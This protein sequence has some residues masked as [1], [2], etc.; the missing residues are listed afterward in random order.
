MSNDRIL[1]EE[2]IRA[3]YQREEFCHPERLSY[4]TGHMEGFLLKRGKEDSR[5]YSRK[6]ILD[7]VDGTLRYFVKE[8]RNPKAILKVPELN[9]VLSPEKIASPNSMQ[10]TFLRDGSTRHIYVKHENPE[11][12]INW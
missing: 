7:E 10:L 11:T 1:I 4:I 5:F 6:F 3:K 2:W 8:D 12:I 9:V